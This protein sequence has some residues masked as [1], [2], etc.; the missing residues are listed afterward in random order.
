MKK[1]TADGQEVIVYTRRFAGAGTHDAFYAHGSGWGPVADVTRA[2]G[3]LWITWNWTLKDGNQYYY[4]G[5]GP[6]DEDFVNG[7]IIGYGDWITPPL[8]GWFQG[9]AFNFV[10]RP[11]TSLK[12]NSAQFTAWQLGP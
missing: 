8:V 11:T 10:A 2:D 5:V 3:S 9:E 7:W 1:L 4:V 12:F 6:G